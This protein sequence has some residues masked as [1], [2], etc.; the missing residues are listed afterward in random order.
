MGLPVV[1]SPNISD[2]SDIIIQNKIGIVINLQQTENMAEA[3]RQM[4][5][6]LQTC[7]RK[8][9][10]EKIF[11]VAKQYR[12]FDIPRRIYPAIYES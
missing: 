4:D 7:D 3:V 9:L 6:L 1:I 12:S 8:T 2:D 11:G 5:L 10:Q